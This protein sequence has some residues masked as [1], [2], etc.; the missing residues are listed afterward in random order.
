MVYTAGSW[1]QTSMEQSNTVDVKWIVIV[2]LSIVFPSITAIHLYMT[3][4]YES[5]CLSSDYTRISPL[6]EISLR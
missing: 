5:S 4:V 2:M 3:T 6:D 1:G